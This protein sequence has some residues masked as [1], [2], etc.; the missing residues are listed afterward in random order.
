LI[1]QDGE[2]NN[3]EE[4]QKL[5]AEAEKLAKLDKEDTDEESEN[6]SR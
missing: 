5:L 1:K 3:N 2:N 4:K 6:E